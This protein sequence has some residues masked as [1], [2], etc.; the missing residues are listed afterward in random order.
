VNPVKG[1]YIVVSKPR[2]FGGGTSHWTGAKGRVKAVSG[3]FCTLVLD[4]ETE[5]LGFFADELTVVDSPTVC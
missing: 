4:G 1:S 2:S 5:E 3:R